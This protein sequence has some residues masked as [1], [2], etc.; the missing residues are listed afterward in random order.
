MRWHQQE[1]QIRSLEQSIAVH[2]MRHQETL[3]LLDRAVAERNALLAVLRAIQP[4]VAAAVGRPNRA[5][6]H[7]LDPLYARLRELGI[8]LS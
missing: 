3:V 7:D 1:R 6:T 4:I 5:E 8:E 2:E